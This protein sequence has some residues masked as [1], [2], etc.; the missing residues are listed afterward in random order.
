MAAMLKVYLLFRDSL[1]EWSA[2]RLPTE[3]GALTVV[4]ASLAFAPWTLSVISASLA[5]LSST[6]F[7]GLAPS[8]DYDIISLNDGRATKLNFLGNI[9][10]LLSFETYL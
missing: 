6:L 9:I 4:S 10:F 2:L 1:L 5:S 8:L 3:P 7:S